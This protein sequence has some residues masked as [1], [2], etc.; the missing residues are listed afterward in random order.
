M[1]LPG[2]G[3]PQSG[4]GYN[5][6]NGP[7]ATNMQMQHGDMQSMGKNT[8]WMGDLD[9]WMD[10]NFVKQIWQQFGEHVNVKMIR[11][12]FSGYV[13]C[14]WGRFADMCNLLLTF[15]CDVE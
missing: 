6:Y 3:G 11:D 2:N 8:L 14:C 7:S 12:K 15:I 13:I 10:E 5:M 4:S 9:P 1:Q